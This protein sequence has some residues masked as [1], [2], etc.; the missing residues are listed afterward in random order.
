MTI[1]EKIKSARIANGLTQEEL[2]IALNTTKQT[3]YKYETGIVTNIPSDK[4][5]L[6]AAKLK[7]TEMYL[8][9][10]EE[11]PKPTAELAELLATIKNDPRLLQLCKDFLRLNPIQQE[12]TIAL[13]H[14]MLPTNEG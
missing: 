2:A 1:G 3:I 9:G 6:L 14:S 11:K 5:E 4:I 10:W 13:I 8:M 12:N 7:V